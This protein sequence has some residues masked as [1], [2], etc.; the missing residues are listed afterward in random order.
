MLIQYKLHY[1]NL[2]IEPVKVLKETG[3]FAVFPRKATRIKTT[4]Y[5]YFNSFE[6]AKSN[7]IFQCNLRLECARADAKRLLETL[8]RLESEGE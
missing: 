3:P 6:E 2:K 7:A 1:C 8:E 4:G 5:L